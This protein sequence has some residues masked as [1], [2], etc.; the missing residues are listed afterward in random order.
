LYA[1][2]DFI[3]KNK[4]FVP[5]YIR[6]A[7]FIEV[8]DAVA[9]LKMPNNKIKSLN[10]NKLKHFFPGDQTELNGE[11]DADVKT[12]FSGHLEAQSILRTT[13]SISKSDCPS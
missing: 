3:G 12:F 6:P 4:K 13:L 10:V 2:T 1:Q 8:N 7:T 9:K 11:Q 5:K